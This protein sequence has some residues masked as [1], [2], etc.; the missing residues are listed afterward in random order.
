MAVNM[1]WTFTGD[2]RPV[3]AEFEHFEG[4]GEV[5]ASTIKALTGTHSIRVP[6]SPISGSSDIRTGKIIAPSTDLRLGFFINHNGLNGSSTSLRRHILGRFTDLS[7]EETI[8]GIA[9]QSSTERFSAT[10]N[11]VEFADLGTLA[12]LGMGVEDRWY[13][14]GLVARIGSPGYAALYVD[15]QPVWQH[16]SE[17]TGDI[18]RV[19]FEYRRG[20]SIAMNTW[21]TNTFM[22]DGYL[23]DITGEPNDPPPPDRFPVR[24]LD[25]VG[26]N[27]EW[28]STEPQNHTAI[29]VNPHNGDASYN[30]SDNDGDR[31]TFNGPT[32]PELLGYLVKSR[33]PY[34]IARRT[35]SVGQI[36]LHTFESPDYLSSDP[37]DL[38]TDYTLVMAQQTTMPDGTSP[39]DDWA[40]I[41]ATQ[42]GYEADG[43]S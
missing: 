15:Q 40:A 3:S 29:T 5:T 9:R 39:L 42:V 35:G 7:G 1:L 13:H 10:I 32:I 21:N 16:T 2:V 36:K 12:S 18:E 43:M 11:G 27:A 22:D 33:H 23:D 8:F 34:A 25:A 37:L 30:Y 4:T 17:L 28:N 26:E 41:S 38:A 14:V 20:T 24:V 6:T 31:D 19:E